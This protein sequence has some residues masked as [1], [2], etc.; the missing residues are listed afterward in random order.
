MS[1]FDRQVRERKEHDR[2][3]LHHA[4]RSL[5]GTVNR[6][7]G[8]DSGMKLNAEEDAALYD[9]CRFYD[10]P[11]KELSSEL[12]GIDEKLNYLLE[13][14]GVMRRRVTLDG[15]W[16]RHM[17]GPVLVRKK[18]DG[19]VVNLM[20]D[21]LGRYYY[22]DRANNRKIRINAKNVS[23]LE[24]EAL[25]FYRP[26]P[27]RKLKASDVLRY[28]MSCPAPADWAVVILGT[29]L[30]TLAGMITP[31]VTQLLFSSVIPAASQLRLMSTAVLLIS[32]AVGIYLLNI[33][34]S[35]YNARIT[36]KVTFGL[37]AASFARMLSLPADFFKNYGTGDM[38]SRV[39]SVQNVGTTLMGVLLNGGMTTVF[40]LIYIFQITN[41]APGMV[42]PA[43]AA[44]SI[45]FAVSIALVLSQRALQNRLVKAGAQL[46]GTVFA[47]FS[48]IQKIKLAGAESRAF[49]RWSDSYQKKAREQFAPPFYMIVLSALMPVTSILGSIII[50][51][52]GASRLTLSEYMAFN[53][54]YG[55]T[56]SAI[57]SFASLAGKLA[58]VGPSLE[59]A[60]PLLETEPEITGE[61]E[62]IHELTGRID[63]TNLSFRY[64]E[65]GPW[66]LD[67]LDLS[68]APGSYVA[69]VGTTGCGKSTLLRLLLGFETPQAGSVFYD[70][71]DI[72]RVDIRSLRR[73][74]GTVLQDGKL[75]QSS[76]FG[77]IVITS[78]DKSLE[79]AWEAAETAQ[80]ADDI[81]AMPMGM[82]TDLSG[83]GISGGQRQRI[84]IA[85]AV[86]PK[87]NILIFDEATSAL[88]NVTQAKVSAALD[89]MKCTRIVVAHRLST[90]RNCDRIIVLDKGR[91]IE[92]GSYEELLEKK[93]FF[94][95][96]AARQ[97]PES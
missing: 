78:S 59:L 39:S 14:R 50:Y 25:C 47:L 80:I 9:L 65:E 23:E 87:P 63:V 41:L 24:S 51:S 4:V 54:A 38:A 57:M 15:D 42:W 11:D 6:E 96:L 13:S 92:D 77:N 37:S 71:K 74:I 86:C 94:A 31:K 61:R 81:R 60:R 40:S 32:M 62:A 85:R 5:T 26:F 79:A 75:F 29:L 73:R 68:I 35:V 33:F 10:L 45:Q 28:A 90:I 12:T 48:G 91:I 17:A 70:G 43:M 1:D 56:A 18:T 97:M 52:A 34:Q 66:V 20:Q 55:M 49:H 21:R 67:G 53:A 84:L 19:A 46:S 64:T 44:I 2:L 27:G 16:W 82:H 58:G 36:Q 89:Q 3:H 93:G 30:V 72:S 7:K 83:G 95:A 69:V 8:Y 88:D 76:V 22:Q